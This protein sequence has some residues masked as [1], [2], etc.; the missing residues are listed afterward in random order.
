MTIMLYATP[1]LDRDDER[2]LAE[3]DQLRQE[4]RYQL[5]EPR[6]WQGQ[7]RRTLTARAIQGS[8]A[9]E[10]YQVSLDD[11]EDAVSGEQPLEGPG[12]VLPEITG[13]REALTYVQQLA[14]NP[15]FRYE[16]MLLSALHF[17]MLGHRLTMSPGR[18]RPGAIFV[19][20]SQTRTVVYEGPDAAAVPALVDELLDWLNNGDLDAP[21]FVR[22]AMAH[23]N[24]VCIH[25]WRDGNGR[26]SRCLQT[27]VLAR[28][29]VL[30]GEFSSIEEWLGTG[31][32]TYDYYDAL[33]ATGQTWAPARG[34][35]SWI[36][37]CL[38]AHHLQA[39][40]VR[41]RFDE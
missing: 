8:N 1:T 28:H 35:R 18:Y 25:P 22:A 33:A 16:R 10:G 13:Y 36:R 19:H 26:M 2:V 39:Q 14:D 7:L 24:L 3:I 27:L 15:D 9:I 32:N 29:G 11:A 30:S 37:F 20:N 40:L 17:M 4:L 23:L 5:A 34:T 38:R 12:S 41:Q 21:V 6:R 31:R